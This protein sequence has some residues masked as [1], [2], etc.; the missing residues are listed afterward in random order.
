MFLKDREQRPP[1]DQLALQ[2]TGDISARI[3]GAMAFFR[4][5]PVLQI[6]T[7]AAA[8]QGGQFTYII[9]GIE[10]Q[11]VYTASQR[12]MGKLFEQQGKLFA[13]IIP[14]LYLNTPNLK[15]DILRDQAAG[16]GIT[17]SR[18][19]SLLRTSYSQNYIY[20]IKKEHDQYQLILEATDRLREHP[21]DLAQLYIT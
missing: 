15:I 10:S 21:E 6:S 13:S 16:Y 18:I 8:R 11:E 5:N 17:A 12:L 7:G 20:L 9:S 2:L 3:R 19:E 4:P 1:I 14:D